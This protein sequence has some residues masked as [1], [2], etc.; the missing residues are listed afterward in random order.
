[1]A[2]LA[3]TLVAEIHA[4]IVL[5]IAMFRRRTWSV[6][7]GVGREV[8]AAAAAAVAVV[9]TAIQHRTEDSMT[10][11][12]NRNQSGTIIVM[13][14]H[15]RAKGITTRMLKFL[16]VGYL[17]ILQNKLLVIRSQEWVEYVK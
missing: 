8:V 6:V 2:Q 10:T 12:V 4:T 1:V 5:I 14:S 17:L 15:R 11:V 3:W 7:V 13:Y 9:I 16:L